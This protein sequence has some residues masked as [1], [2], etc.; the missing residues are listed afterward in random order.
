MTTD[1]G[2]QM[3]GQYTNAELGIDGRYPEVFDELLEPWKAED[4]H[5]HLYQV[6]PPERSGNTYR[7]RMID[8]GILIT[9]DLPEG[10]MVQA[11]PH[12]IYACTMIHYHGDDYEPLEGSIEG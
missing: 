12:A 1:Y 8:D 7:I 3:L 9:L 4:P 2:E 6:H 10:M 5:L 11:I